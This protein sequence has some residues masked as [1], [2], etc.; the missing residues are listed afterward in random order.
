MPGFRFQLDPVIR[1]R[2][3][4]ERTRQLAV[5]ALERE[6][7]DAEE[8]LRQCGQAV[9]AGKQEIRRLLAPGQ[10]AVDLRSARFQAGAGLRLLAKS[11]HAAIKLAGTHAR[12]AAA[13]AELL[14]AATARKAVEKLR[15][16][17]YEAWLQEQ[18]MREDAAIDE[19]AVIRGNA[20]SENSL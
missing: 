17:R 6:R 11:Q 14:K 19:M 8:E 2:A 1:Q 10:G 5:A 15:E 13:R 7:L 18:K 20:T 16:R 12:L 3:A 4:L 9:L